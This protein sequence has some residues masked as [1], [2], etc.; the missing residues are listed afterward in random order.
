MAALAIT[1]RVYA[2]AHRMHGYIRA[3][4]HDATGK[5]QS[6]LFADRERRG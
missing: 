6:D 5:L 2:Y 4:A 3:V 1:N